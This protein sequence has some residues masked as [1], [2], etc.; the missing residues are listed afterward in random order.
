[1]GPA[2]FRTGG[3]EGLGSSLLHPVPLFK[4][5]MQACRGHTP[6]LNNVGDMSSLLAVIA[7]NRDWLAGTSRTGRLGGGGARAL[8]G[9]G[10]PAL[11]RRLSRA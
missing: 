7:W 3:G 5:G 11:M 10:L 6:L 8:F 1:M 9:S 4:V 2:A